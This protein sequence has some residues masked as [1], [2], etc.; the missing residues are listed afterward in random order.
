MTN[1]NELLSEE[2]AV[3]RPSSG[4]MLLCAD[5][6]ASGDASTSKVPTLERDS[7]D[8]PRPSRA[9]GSVVS[10]TVK[11]NYKL[12]ESLKIFGLRTR[13]TNQEILVYALKRVLLDFA[14]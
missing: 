12:Y 2:T 13:Q 11:L 10:V 8:V 7:S 9:R 3:I 1:N 5:G 14:E 6:T 4:P